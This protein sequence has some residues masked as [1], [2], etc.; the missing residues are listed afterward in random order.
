M[1][2]YTSITAGTH[3]QYFFLYDQIRQ[4]EPGN[5]DVIIWNFPSVKFVFDS[6]KKTRPSSDPLIEPA[7][8]LSSPIFRTHPMDTTFLSNSIRMVLDPLLA[9]VHQSYSPFS[10]ATTT[11]YFSGPSRRSFT[12]VSVINWTH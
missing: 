8:S 3:S 4:L 10:L 7:I 1:A 5:S 2:T 11:I 12:L 6:A 9:S